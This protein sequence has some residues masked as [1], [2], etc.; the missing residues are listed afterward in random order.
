MDMDMEFQKRLS[1][2]AIIGRG[3]GRVMSPGWLLRIG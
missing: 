2:A 1:M 3:P